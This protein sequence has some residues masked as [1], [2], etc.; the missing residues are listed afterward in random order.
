MQNLPYHLDCFHSLLY[1]GCPGCF[2]ASCSFTSW[3]KRKDICHCSLAEKRQNA[4]LNRIVFKKNEQRKQNPD[5]TSDHTGCFIGILILAYNPYITGQY[6]TLY[7]VNKQG[8]GWGSWSHI[9]LGASNMNWLDQ[10]WIIISLEKIGCTW[11][12]TVWWSEPFAN[13]VGCPS[14]Y[15]I[16]IWIYKTSTCQAK[17]L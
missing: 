14:I 6:N 10:W 4:V 8:Q 2:G 11:G 12:E 13:V 7:T 3:K 5:M 17:K 15:Y 1:R 9:F 16:Y